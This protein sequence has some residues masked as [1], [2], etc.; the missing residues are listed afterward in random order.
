M[1]SFGTLICTLLMVGLALQPVQ[2]TAAT[3]SS[4]KSVAKAKAVAAAKIKAKA[5][6]KLKAK[7]A[8]SGLRAASALASVPAPGAGPVDEAAL[9]KEV[10]A[11]RRLVTAHPNDVEARNRLAHA[12]VVLID[13]LLH[14]EAVGDTAKARRFAQKL[15]RDQHDAGSR[16]QALAQRGDLRARQALGFLLD[17]GILLEKNAQKSCTEFVAAGE[18][19]AP[20]AWHAAQ[21]QMETSPDKAWV[22]MERASLRGHAAAQEWMGRR[23]LGEFGRAEKDYVCAREYLIQSA[24][25][26]RSRA[27][28]LLAYLLI[29]GQGGPVDVSR[30]IRLY[31]TAAEHGDVNAQNNLGEIHETGRGITKDLDQAILWYERAAEKG[32]GSAQFNAG[33]LWAIGV[34]EKRD[35][36]KARVLLLQAEGNGVPQARQVLD[37][38]DR[39]AAPAAPDGASVQ[40]SG[41]TSEGVSKAR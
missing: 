26:G 15:V 11:A 17:R 35:P 22:W 1:K 8:I 9:D 41:A 10:A 3:K 23:C 40:K 25:M 4:A 18:K 36:A 28:T 12:T 27:Q 24:S 29:T 19:F 20:S 38:L 16:V 5:K 31:R 2:V 32:L 39:Q 13:W 7:A 21:C 6:S 14:A 37:W 33:R 34:G 30:A